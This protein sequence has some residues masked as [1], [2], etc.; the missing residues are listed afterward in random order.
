MPQGKMLAF[1]CI[2][3]ALLGNLCAQILPFRHYTHN[4]GLATND[5]TSFY[6][7]GLRFLWVS[8]ANGVSRFDGTQFINYTMDDG[9]TSSVVYCVR[10]SQ[11]WL[12]VGTQ[13]GLCR[14]PA[15]IT[16]E[17]RI[18]TEFGIGSSRKIFSLATDS[19]GTL[20]CATEKGIFL[21]RG[22]SVSEF[23]IKGKHLIA[24]SLVYGTDSMMLILSWSGL[25][26]YDQ[27]TSTVKQIQ[28][29]SKNQVAAITSDRAGNIWIAT[30]D[31]FLRQYVGTTFISQKSVNTRIKNL[32][33]DTEGNL[34]LSTENGLLSIRTKNI[35]GEKFVHYT[36]EQGLL[37]NNI[38]CC[39]VDVEK[40]LWIAVRNKGISVLCEKHSWI[41]PFEGISEAYNNGRAV[42][43]TNG[44]FWV[45]TKR[46]LEEIWREKN[47]GW[48]TYRHFKGKPISSIVVHGEKLFVNRGSDIVE[49]EIGGP[50][51]QH[52]FL[53]QSRNIKLPG[54]QQTAIVYADSKN[55]LWCNVRTG[56]IKIDSQQ[57]RLFTKEDCLPSNDIRVIFEDYEGNMWF[58]GYDSGISILPANASRMIS[59]AEFSHISKQ[60]MVPDNMIRAI[61]QDR[62]GKIWI[63]MRYKGISVY[64]NG[65]ITTIK[66]LVNNSVWALSESNDGTM[67]AATSF[68]MQKIS[69]RTLLPQK[70]SDFLLG[71]PTG[72]C[73]A[74]RD[75][76][77]WYVT[78]E[79]FRVY[80]YLS[81]DVALPP[82]VYI[83]RID[84]N[85]KML[86][87]TG[88]F[89]FPYDHNNVSIEF[90]GIDYRQSSGLLYQY[91]LIGTGKEWSN[92]TILRAASYPALHPGTYIFEVRALNSEGVVSILPAQ[93]P[94]VIISPF[95]Q[96]WW[97]QSFIL[98]GFLS[99]GPIIY[100]RRVSQLQKEKRRQEEFSSQL[101][102]SQEE[103]RKRIASELHDSIGQNLL[104]IKNSAVLGRNRRD[105][106]RYLDINQTASSSIE[107]V[108]RIAY[109]LFPYQL[110]Q[111]GLTK[112]IESVV[113][114]VSE[115]S[116][117]QFYISVQNIDGIFNKEQE[118]SIF[119]ILQECLNNVIKHS[120]ADKGTVLVKV[121]DGTLMIT[122]GDNGRGFN[123]E[124][125]R[126]ES[127][128]FGLRNT[129]NRIILLRGTITYAA[130]KEYK[131]LITVM[132]PIKNE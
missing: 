34:W 12:W 71:T 47:G 11:G 55:N 62:E 72:S 94:F 126:N 18:F 15:N 6:Q 35:S 114:N 81:K 80:N 54:N 111:L 79:A 40:N 87:D 118:S 61:T 28:I 127:K 25:Y 110:D 128:G 20:W 45:A 10:E 63:G 19:Q 48:K 68:G 44:H 30:S 83:T 51:D 59:F 82:P 2:I 46:G 107:E 43:D 105:L 65:H 112:A 66:G 99:I 120:G 92:P 58:G 131:T 119:R 115:S 124:R 70:Q 102:N 33:A 42:T 77:L 96:R 91:R 130:S 73:G 101:I 97:F 78:P 103:E 88:T 100:F 7:D 57:M 104:F 24:N 38:E 16:S 13:D 49:F 95:W 14:S 117:I 36:T 125:M 116:T 22:D 3:I 23:F 93:F 123:V 84:V 90:T 8:N 85:A 29:P 75:G 21:I 27:N 56:V 17:R 98:F 74:Q 41:F 9:L 53:K 31:G 121:N 4:E 32:F 122:I 50:Q 5:V 106:K 86:S 52:S 76:L 113:R 39:L 89:E 132:L 37:G 67:W 108:R 26:M 60:Q 64:G 129:H 69:I 109:N 1:I